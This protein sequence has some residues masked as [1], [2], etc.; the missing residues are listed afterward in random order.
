MFIFEAVLLCHNVVCLLADDVVF[1]QLKGAS[2]ANGEQNGGS[3]TFAKD[4]KD[5]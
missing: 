4:C 3:V 5:D 1:P 2:N